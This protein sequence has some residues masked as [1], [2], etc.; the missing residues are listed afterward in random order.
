MSEKIYT[1]LF[2]LYPSRFRKEYEDEAL[3]LIRDRFR[4]E[5]G[6]FKRFRLLCDL[7]VDLF[8]G[9]PLAHRNSYAATEAVSLSLHAEGIPSFK[10]L[11][12]EP[13]G[14]GSILLGSGLSLATIVAFGFLLSRSVAHLPV[15]DSNGRMSPIEAVVARLNRPE[16]PDPPINGPEEAP[17]SASVRSE[18]QPRP[19]SVA[20]ASSAKSA[21]PAS[22]P[23]SSNVAGGPDRMIAIPTQNPNERLM[24]QLPYFEPTAWN[25]NLQD[26]SGRPVPY[27]EIH[28]IAGHGELVTHTAADGSFAFSELNS[29]DYE[30][31]VVMNGREI[32]YRKTLHLGT[33]SSPSRLTLAPGGRVL[34]SRAGKQP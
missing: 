7:A 26:A 16:S 10:I 9:L 32:A 34:F 4:D 30:M 3:Q 6:F 19:P 28:L 2:R 5:T 17:G 18:E 23:E 14:R 11:A 31:A 22:L 12:T 27:A 33:T 8:V 21:A 24:T 29:G 20:H 25:G 13:I 1:R 15:P